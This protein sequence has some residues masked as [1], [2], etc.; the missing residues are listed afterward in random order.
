MK[1]KLNCNWAQ[2]KD[3]MCNKA[4]RAFSVRSL[5][6]LAFYNLIFSFETIGPK[7][8]GIEVPIEI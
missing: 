8:T 2:S 3:H 4:K 6:P 7:L 1:I 5:K